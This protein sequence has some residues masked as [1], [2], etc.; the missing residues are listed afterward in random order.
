M[1]LVEVDILG[2]ISFLLVIYYNNYLIIKI[3]I[4]VI[5][6]NRLGDIFIL[7]ILFYLVNNYN[8]NFYLIIFNYNLFIFFL[9]FRSASNLEGCWLKPHS[10]GAKVCCAPRFSEYSACL[11]ISRFATRMSTNY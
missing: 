11:K 3:S 10:R 6:F 2:L 7:I 4:L 5:I 9:I 1:L 8:L